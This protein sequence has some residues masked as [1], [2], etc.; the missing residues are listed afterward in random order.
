MLEIIIV[1]YFKYPCQNYYDHSG[2]HGK[3]N[4]TRELSILN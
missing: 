4:T 1:L 3:N 2:E